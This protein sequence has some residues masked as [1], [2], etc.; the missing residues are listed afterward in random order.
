MA[1]LLASS[2][3]STSSTVNNENELVSTK[4]PQENSASISSPESSSN[5]PSRIHSKLLHRRIVTMLETLRKPNDDLSNSSLTSHSD[6]K[7]QPITFGQLRQATVSTLSTT[8]IE[9]KSNSQQIK[10]DTEKTHHT[11]MTSFTRDSCPDLSSNTLKPLTKHQTNEKRLYYSP[12][13]EQ[14]FEEQNG[15]SQTKKEKE[16]SHQTPSTVEEI[17]A[18]YYSKVNLSTNN[19]ESHL[20]PPSNSNTT[21]GFYIHPS[22]PRWNSSQSNQNNILLPPPPELVLNEQNRNRPPP[23]SYSSSVTH[24][25][26]PSSTSM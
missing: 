1:E 7:S 19:T 20:S 2:F 13:L 16:Q 24:S 22:G 3:S 6:Q 15:S 10:I 4:S 26:R 18:M 5:D 12:S 17:L 11:T 9:D 21:T 8:I 23:P 25:H 14:L